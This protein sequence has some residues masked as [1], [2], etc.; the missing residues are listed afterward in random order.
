VVTL[1][2]DLKRPT[3]VLFDDSYSPYWGARWNGRTIPVMLAD[4]N[5]MAVALPAEH[6]TLSFEFRPQLF[7]RLFKIG[8]V[9]MLLVLLLLAYVAQQPG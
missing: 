8:S 6:G 1:D 7:L 3:I 9:T 5:F 2:L 4:G